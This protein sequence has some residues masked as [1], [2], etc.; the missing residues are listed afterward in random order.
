MVWPLSTTI[1]VAWRRGWLSLSFG[2]CTSADWKGFCTVPVAV[3]SR[4][5][6]GWTAAVRTGCVAAGAGACA[7]G[8]ADCGEAGGGRLERDTGEAWLTATGAV[9]ILSPG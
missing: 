7:T 5:G 9:S 6:A 8:E 1:S 3:R 2:A 4:L